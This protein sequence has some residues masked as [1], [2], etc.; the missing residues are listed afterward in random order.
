M[1]TLTLTS[2]I[3]VV[4]YCVYAIPT[5]AAP[6]VNYTN[7]D[8]IEKAPDIVYQQQD[9]SKG[10]FIMKR[11]GIRYLRKQNRQRISKEIKMRRR[12]IT[13]F[14]YTFIIV[15]ELCIKDVCKNV[16]TI[17]AIVIC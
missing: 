4:L 2:V 7:L 14:S 15:K 9:E 13:C 17:N 12:P 8:G 10:E 3:L 6:T 11:G 16:E 5:S 1:M